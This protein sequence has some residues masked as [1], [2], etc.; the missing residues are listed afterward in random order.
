MPAITTNKPAAGMSATSGPMFE[1]PD[2]GSD[3]KEEQ[4]LA[5]VPTPAVPS[6]TTATATATTAQSASTEK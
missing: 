5:P 6:A 2:F 1:E 3:T 4:P